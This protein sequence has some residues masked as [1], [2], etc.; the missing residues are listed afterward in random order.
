VLL[1]QH[2]P[3]IHKHLICNLVLGCAREYSRANHSLT[4]FSPTPTSSDTTPSFI[5]LHFESNY[6]FPLFLKDY[7]LDQD[8]E[9]SSNSFKLTFQHMLH[10]LTSG[11]FGMVFEHFRNCF[12]FEDPEMNSFSYFL[13]Y[14]QGSHSTL[15]CTCFWHNLPFSHDQAFKQSS[16]YCSGGN[17]VSIHKLG[18]M[19][20][21]L[22]C[23]CN[24]FIPTLIRNRNKK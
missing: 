13:S 1:L 16:S 8:L 5:T 17:I 23:L 22:Q 6:Y 24:T 12:H 11:F 21:I 19:P 3:P 10:L 4:P 20:S 15:N 18:F 9:L 7:E 2:D 14:C